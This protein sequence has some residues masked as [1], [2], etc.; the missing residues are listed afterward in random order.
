MAR[1]TNDPRPRDHTDAAKDVARELADVAGQ[2]AQLK[3]EAMNWLEDSN[4]SALKLRLENAH[5]AVEAAV[6]EARR[7]VRINEEDARRR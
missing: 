1:K 5:S 3:G 2:L 6:V 4:Y 7:R